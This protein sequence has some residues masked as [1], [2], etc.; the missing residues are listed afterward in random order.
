MMIDDDNHDVD[1]ELSGE[2]I[3]G[4]IQYF[5]IDSADTSESLVQG[6]KALLGLSRS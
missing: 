6:V 4:L 1:D 2:E 3:D 5:G